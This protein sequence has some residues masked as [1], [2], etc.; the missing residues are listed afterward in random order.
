MDKLHEYETEKRIIA[1]KGLSPAEYDTE[2][3]ELIERLG[4]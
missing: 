4:I 3:Q 2:I 1:S